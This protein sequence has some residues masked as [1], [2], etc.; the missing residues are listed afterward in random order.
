M[1]IPQTIREMRMRA[2]LTQAELG[3][4]VGTKGRRISHYETEESTPTLAMFLN[5]ANACGYKLVIKKL[6]ED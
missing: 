5:I 4:K 6:D 2:G 3:Y 1:D